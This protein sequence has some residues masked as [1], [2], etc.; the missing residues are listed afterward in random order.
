MKKISDYAFFW[1]F[2]TV[3]LGFVAIKVPDGWYQVL[4]AILSILCLY[5]FVVTLMNRRV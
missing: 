2:L 4:Y 3:A 5:E 1:F